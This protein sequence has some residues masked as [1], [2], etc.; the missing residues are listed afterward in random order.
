MPAQAGIQPATPADKE[1]FACDKTCVL[2]R[3]WMPACAGMTDLALS[4]LALLPAVVA[5]FVRVA[6]RQVLARVLTDL[7]AD[8]LG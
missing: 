5:A 8:L 2:S 6:R 4:R 3:R 1:Q 7:A